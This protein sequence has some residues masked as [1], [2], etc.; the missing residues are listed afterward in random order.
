EPGTIWAGS[1]RLDVGRVRRRTGDLPGAL[2]WLEAAA[3]T[4]PEG[5]RATTVTDLLRAEI[6]HELGDDDAAPGLAGD[7]RDARAHGLVVSRARRLVERIRE[8]PDEEPSPTERLA[9][10][11]LRLTEG[12]AHGAQREALAVLGSAPT[13]DARDHALW[14]QARAAHE[15]GT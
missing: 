7:V 6:G 12:D 14:I 1:A 4:F 15:L 10:A 3:D 5:E 9:E 11:E 2:D 8:R 13:R